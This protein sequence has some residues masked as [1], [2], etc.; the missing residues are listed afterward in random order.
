VGTPW[1]GS[2][3]RPSHRE[4]HTNRAAQL[5]KGPDLRGTYGLFSFYTNAP[6]S[7]F[8]VDSGGEVY[9]VEVL[10]RVVKAKLYGPQNSFYADARP[11]TVD[12]TVFI[13]PENPITKIQFQ[14]QQI[15]LQEGEWS[16]W[17][18][19]EL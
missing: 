2:H 13:D 1:G 4:G 10:D 7:K 18:G 8:S 3:K 12:L 9:K 16:P 15:I 11:S 6:D 19:H 14:D 5:S 17:Q